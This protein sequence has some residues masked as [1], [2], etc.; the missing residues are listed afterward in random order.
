MCVFHRQENPKTGQRQWQHIHELE[1]YNWCAGAGGTLGMY[2]MWKKNWRR[3]G[4]GR[5]GGEGGLRIAL[6]GG[7]IFGLGEGEFQPR[8]I[9]W[10]LHRWRFRSYSWEYLTF[11]E[12]R[13]FNTRIRREDTKKQIK[14][15]KM[16]ET[17]QAK[18]RLF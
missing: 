3:G 7:H 4:G 11:L 12:T 2:H 6:L 14:M 16:R 17:V 9:P 15:C 18:T 13:R 8:R 1:T 10:L 5:G